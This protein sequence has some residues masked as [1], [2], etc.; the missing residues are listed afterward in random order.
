MTPRAP[1]FLPAVL[2]ACVAAGV[3]SVAASERATAT[4]SANAQVSSRTSL[5]VS[6]D[7]LRFDVTDPGTPAVVSVDFVAG[8]RTQADGEVVLTVEPVRAIEGPGGAADVEASVEFAGEGEGTLAGAIEPAA[9]AVAGRW[10][11]SG[12]H[13]G[14]LRFSLRTGAAGA[15]TLPVR[16]VL[17]AP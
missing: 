16:F 4:I 15:Y 1:S 2:I 3:S 12:R 11:G 8:A 9:S 7:T 17:T 10:T 13:T 6:A 5:I 14:R